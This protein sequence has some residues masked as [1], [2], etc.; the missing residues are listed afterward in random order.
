MRA[1]IPYSRL[2][3]AQIWEVL[4]NGRAA[5][6]LIFFNQSAKTTQIWVVTRHQHGGSSDIISRETDGGVAKWGCSLRLGLK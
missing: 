6:E 2:V 3:T 1:D 5:K 4:S